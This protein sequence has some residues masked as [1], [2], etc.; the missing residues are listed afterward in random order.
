MGGRSF[1]VSPRSSLLTENV[2]TS[3]PGGAGRST[4]VVF[5]S[6]SKSSIAHVGG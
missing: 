1:T 3:V 6:T 4:H 5:V 2:V